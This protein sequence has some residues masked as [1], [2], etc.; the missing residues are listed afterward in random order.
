MKLGF[1]F[2]AWIKERRK[3]PGKELRTPPKEYFY[4]KSKLSV[5]VTLLVILQVS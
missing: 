1:E 4:F 2:G 3:F 5:G